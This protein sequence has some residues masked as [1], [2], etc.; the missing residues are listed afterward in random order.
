MRDGDPEDV[1]RQDD[2]RVGAPGSTVLLL[3]LLS[4][5]GSCSVLALVLT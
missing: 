5:L 3:L 4:L 1:E 2:E